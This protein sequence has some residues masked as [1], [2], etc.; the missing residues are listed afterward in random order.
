[1]KSS[2]MYWVKYRMNQHELE[3][4]IAV[5]AYNKTEA[6]FKAFYDKIPAEHDGH[7]PYSAWVDNVTYSNGNVRYFNTCE[8][9]PY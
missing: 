4:G 2:C 7:M 1:M 6:Y 3:Q 8:G 9:L 5:L